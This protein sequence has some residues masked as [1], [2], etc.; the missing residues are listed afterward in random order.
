MNNDRV[1][2]SEREANYSNL[3]EYNLQTQQSKAMGRWL[4]LAGFDVS[5]SALALGYEASRTG[6]VVRTRIESN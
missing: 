2:Y 1:I 5:G 3:L 6:D 4:Y